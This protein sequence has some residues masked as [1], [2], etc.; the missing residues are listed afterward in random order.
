[1]R[2]SSLTPSPGLQIH[3]LLHLYFPFILVATKWIRS[4]IGCSTDDWLGI[5]RKAG[6]A[7]Q[8]GPSGRGTM[9]VDIKFKVP[10]QYEL[11]ILKHNSYCNVNERLSST[12]WTTL[13][14][15]SRY[16]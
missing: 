16:M 4:K 15:K 6:F 2:M 3:N 13:Y 9:F 11:L 5:S 1:M 7:L 14:S 10:P 8:G 12:R